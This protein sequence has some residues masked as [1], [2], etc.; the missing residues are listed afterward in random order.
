M[1]TTSF[2]PVFATDGVTVIGRR[3]NYFFNGV[4]ARSEEFPAEAEMDATAQNAYVA[5]KLGMLL[6]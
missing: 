3:L 2:E 5:S 4:L 6:G 1:I